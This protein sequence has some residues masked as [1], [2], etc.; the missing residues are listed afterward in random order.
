MHVQVLVVPWSFLEG[1]GHA[2]FDLPI[3]FPRIYIFGSCFC[4]DA[5]FLHDLYV[6][7]WMISVIYTFTVLVLGNSICVQEI[8]HTDIIRLF[9]TWQKLWK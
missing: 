7:S 6:S 4:F 9:K 5:S 2:S 3:T 8:D 1:W